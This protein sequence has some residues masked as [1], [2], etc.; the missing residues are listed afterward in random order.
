M[1]HSED[2]LRNKGCVTPRGMRQVE[3]TASPFYA[4]VMKLA[5]MRDLKS[6]DLESRVGS[7]PTR[8]TIWASAGISRQQ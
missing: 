8:R 6:L 5:D 3:I 2:Q 7:N 1:E 4:P